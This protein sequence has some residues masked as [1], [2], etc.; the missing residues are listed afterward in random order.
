MLRRGRRVMQRHR[1]HG[2]GGLA[3]LLPSGGGGVNAFRLEQLR[4]D[5]ES[6]RQGAA[7]DFVGG[8][9]DRSG[10]VRA[11]PFADEIIRDG[12]LQAV[13]LEVQSRG[14]IEPDVKALLSY[15]CRGDRI[16]EIVRVADRVRWNAAHSIAPSVPSDSPI[17]SLQLALVSNFRSRLRRV[18]A[19]T[20]IYHFKPTIRRRTSPCSARIPWNDGPAFG[21]F[22]ERPCRHGQ[23]YVLSEAK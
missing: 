14:V 13:L 7:E 6:H 8:F 12:N 16:C 5:A 9:L 20:A 15:P 1:L 23:Q 17:D 19:S 18:L 2:S 11:D 4:H 10:E 22:D 3:R 21:A